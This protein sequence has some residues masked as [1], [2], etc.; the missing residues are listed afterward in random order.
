MAG[1]SIE[2]KI[3]QMNREILQLKTAHPVASN[4]I[5]FYQEFT[6][7]NDLDNKTHRYEITYVDGT[8]P[9][10]TVEAYSNNAWDLLFSDVVN[11]KQIMYDMNASHSGG[12]KF[13]IISTRQ[14]YSIRKLS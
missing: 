6:F 10:L 9:I 4:M 14:I 3:R 2:Q 7:D 12:E 11:N 5:T 8:Q 1:S 13:G